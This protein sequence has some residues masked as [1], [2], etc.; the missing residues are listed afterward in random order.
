M[1]YT[2]PKRVRVNRHTVSLDDYEHALVLAL[3]NYKGDEPAVVIR[4][5]AMAEARQIFEASQDESVARR[6]A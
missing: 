3:A 6:F 5:L 1:T 2:D 4:D